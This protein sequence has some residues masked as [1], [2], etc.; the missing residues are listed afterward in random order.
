MESGEY[1]L[2]ALSNLFGLHQRNAKVTYKPTLGCVVLE[3]DS[4]AQR[5]MSVIKGF[6]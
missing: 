3:I 2:L 5:I 4:K 6:K 1:N